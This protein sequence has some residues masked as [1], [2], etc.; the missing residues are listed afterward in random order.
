M[1]YETLPFPSERKLVVDAGYLGTGRHIF[2][3]LVEVDV[4]NLRREMDRRKAAGEDLSFTAC[5]AA[6]LGQAIAEHPEVQ[7]YRDWR[8]RLVLFQEVDV[9]VMVEPSPGRAAI[10]HIIRNA[11]DR[12]VAE[13]SAEIRAV[14][15]G[16]GDKA[17]QASTLMRL[18]PHVPRFLR[19]W[20]FHFIKLSPPRFKRLEGTTIITSLGMFGK[21]SGWGIT[22]L[23]VHT[24]GLTV[25]SIVEK[26]AAQQGQVVLREILHLTLAFDHDLVDGAP[27][28]RFTS[29]LVEMLEKGE[30]WEEDK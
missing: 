20:F 23:P 3:G 30:M 8:G 12:S 1:N 21:L 13:I 27:A 17:G 5:I 7:A 22:F 6:A 26:P 2:Y 15:A 9:V 19:L 11:Q 18:A 4:T 14:Q 29:R 10:P 16:S 24:L 25:G 28:A